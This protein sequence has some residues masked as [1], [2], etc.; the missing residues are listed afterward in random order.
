[1]KFKNAADM[2]LSQVEKYGDRA[3]LKHK[4][5]GKWASVTWKEWGDRVQGVASGL[6]ALGLKRG[7]R[8]GILSAN[9]VDWVASD[10]GIICAGGT[11]VGIYAS[12]LPHEV[13]YIAGHAESPFL[14]AE[15]KNQLDKILQVRSKLTD[16]KKVIVFDMPSGFEHPDVIGIDELI[17]LGNEKM[18]DGRRIIEDV[19][20]NVDPEEVVLLVYTSGTTGPPKG[21]MLT[22]NNILWTAES[23]I[24]EMNITENDESMSFL[25]L[26]HLLEHFVFFGVVMLGATINF[27]E[28]I[29]KL[30]QNL[31]EV[32]PTMMVAVPR[33]YE[34]IYAKLQNTAKQKGGAASKI[35]KM[36]QRTAIDYARK[37]SRGE[38][39][40]ISLKLKHAISDKL[41]Y[42]KLR[43]AVGGRM[44]FLG[45]GGA[46]LGAEIAEF[47][48]GAGLPIIESWGMTETTAPATITLPHEV[49]PG[50]VG[51]PIP[52]CEVK[53]AEDGEIL[54]KGPNV[55]KGYFKN[56]QATSEALIDGWM[57]TGD[58]GTFIEDGIL[59]IT[60]RKKDLIITA[61]GKNIA[62]QNIENLMKT[63][64]LFSQVVLVGDRQPYCVALITLNEDELKRMAEQNGLSAKTRDEL[65]AAPQIQEAVSKAVA[66]KN[67]YLARFE[68][69]KKWRVLSQDFSQET[70]ELTP[71]LK[72]KRKIVNQKYENF[73]KEMYEEK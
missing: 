52:G 27:A 22:H 42:S 48:Y 63:N 15:N 61:G 12:N 1:M 10:L 25:P 5:S 50:A 64:P 56:P 49:R 30:G 16:L 7:D 53:I 18:D 6:S 45:S 21:A 47:F 59:K 36:A 37:H 13:G 70:G 44:K 28:S 62:P 55:F 58:V 26:A 43:A 11:T 39:L 35:F 67:S 73:I 33:V 32:K 72:V 4:A 24:K 40:P 68:Q 51:R 65:I 60:D 8:V 19:R 69:V 66:E 29:D 38:P 2:F 34:K 46:P 3:A 9:R 23:G 14:F 20:R 57:H 71:T 41:V 54:V 17:A 31:V